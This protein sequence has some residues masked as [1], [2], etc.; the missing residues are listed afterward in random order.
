MGIACNA[1]SRTGILADPS[2][3][4]ALETHRD[5]FS[6]HNSDTIVSYL[7]LLAFHHA[8][9]ASAAAKDSAPLRLRPYIKHGRADGDEVQRQTVPPMSRLGGQDTGVD[10]TTHAIEKVLRN[11]G[12]VAL[13]DIAGPHTLGG[14]NVGLLVGSI[15][16]EKRNMGAAAR[17]VLDSLDSVRAGEPAVEVN[18]PYPPL[19]TAAAMPDRDLAGI[20]AAA[21]GHALLGEGQWQERPAFPQVVI[22][23]TLQMSQAGGSRLV[24]PHDLER[25]ALGLGLRSRSGR[26]RDRL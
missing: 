25:L 19:C 9:R 17:V 8:E 18:G 24:R 21:L 3:L 26:C 4:T 15:L 2:D 10:D 16:V 1:D 14:N 13:D 22:D 23:G 5:I 6:R 7:F 12:P 11:A 20:V